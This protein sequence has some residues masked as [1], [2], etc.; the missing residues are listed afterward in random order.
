MID[1]P[2]PEKGRKVFEDLYGRERGPRRFR[3]ILKVL[4]PL[5]V[6]AAVVVL[7]A[8]IAGSGNAIYSN[9]R[10]W[11]FP[12]PPIQGPSQSAGG[13][14]K[15]VIKGGENKGVQIQNCN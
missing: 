2:D 14:Q 7:V 8:Q 9:V 11:L 10:G 15:C 5:I 12:P 3:A 4:V 6:I 1:F 13:T